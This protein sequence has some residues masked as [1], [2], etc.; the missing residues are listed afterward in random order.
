M[1]EDELVWRPAT[2]LVELYRRGEAS[3]VE[4]A[5]A[6]L[7]R[8]EQV[9]PTLNAF[10]HTDPE[11]TLAAARDSEQRWHRGSPAGPVDGVPTS[12]K[13]QLLTRGWP[14]RRGSRTTAAEAGV[15]IDQA[16]PDDSP[17][18]ARLRERGAVLVGK[19]TTPEFGWKGVTDSPL[20]GITRNPW[21]PACTPGGSSGGAAAAVA[22]G[23][24]QLALGTDGAGSVRIPASFA[25]VVGLKATFAQVPVY[26]SSAFGT[27][28]HTG[29]LTRTVADTA[30]LLDVVSAADPR[31]P[32]AVPPPAVPFRAQLGAGEPGGD[33]LAGLRIGFSPTLGY[34][35]VDPEVASLVAA[36]VEVLRGLGAEVDL[37]DPGFADPLEPLE[38]LWC[39]GAAALLRGVP[40]QRR[41]LVD[42]GLRAMAE[43]GELLTGVDVVLAGVERTRLG[44]LMTALHQRFPV[45][46]TPTMPIPAFTAGQDVPDGWPDPAWTSWT[47]FTYPFNLT[48]QP[49]LTVPC[50]FTAGGLPVGLQL[51]ANRFD[52]ALLL[53]VGHRYQQVTDWHTRRPA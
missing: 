21:R 47:P 35:R 9:D 48:Q 14:T 3:P 40:A 37:V 23:M 51:V 12:I 31:D 1:T 4:A 5:Q 26:P 30:L 27:L 22:A 38:T 53:R 29:P 2:E 16:W 25:G 19:T 42:P 15:A 10:C 49:A 39:A 24:G 52:D 43:R 6:V 46:V 32:W 41:E 45:L 8:I 20:T 11:T 7:R 44:L 17:A 36:A 28:S 33:A 34:V 50:G 13:D 18:V